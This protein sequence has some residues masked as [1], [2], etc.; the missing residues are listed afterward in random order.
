MREGNGVTFALGALIDGI[1]EQ[2]VLGMG[3]AGGEGVSI[4]L[5]LAI[6]VS[7]MPEAIGSAGDLRAAGRSSGCPPGS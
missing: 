5:L 3:I 1:P 2:L 6:Y 7:N 4:S